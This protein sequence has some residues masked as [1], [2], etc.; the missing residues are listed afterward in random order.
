MRAKNDTQ[1]SPSRPAP[2]LRPALRAT[3]SVVTALLALGLA[4]L[5]LATTEVQ[6]A[7]PATLTVGVSPGNLPADGLSTA[8]VV[9]TATDA[10]G[11]PV[12]DGTTVVF[13]TTAGYLSNWATVYTGTTAGGVATATLT[14]APSNGDV[15]VTVHATSGGVS[16]SGAVTF[17]AAACQSDFT[18]WSEYAVNP[19]FDPAQKVYYPTVI[20]DANAFGH[21]QGDVISAS[22]P[23]TYV[24]TPYYKMW[25]ARS[26]A[27]QGLQFVYSDD[28]LNWHQFDGGAQLPGLAP[29][30]YHSRVLYDAGGF[31]GS[32]YYYKIWY[33][34]PS[35]SIYGITAVRTA[36]STDGLVWAN[37]QAL[38]QSL[39]MP[40]ITGASSG[41]NRGSYGPVDVLYD[42]SAI[43]SGTDPFDYSFV[44]YYDATTGG[45][46]QVGLG[47]S[48]DGVF[49][50][51]YGDGPVLS[52]GSD[53]WGDPTPWDSSYVGTGTVIK[54]AS[55]V[56]RFWYSGGTTALHHGIGYAV[57]ADGIHW[58]KSLDNP[59][60]HIN[61]GVSYR[62]AR[63]Y[64]PMVVRSTGGFD[65]HGPAAEYKMWFTADDGSNRAIGYAQLRPAAT[66][67]AA[68]GSSQSGVV[69]TPLS[70]P[71]VARAANTCDDPSPGVVVDFAVTGAPDGASGQNLSAQTAT[72]DAS[73]QASTTLTLGSH[74]GVY[75][76]TASSAGLS[77]S[78]VVFTATAVAPDLPPSGKWADKATAKAG[79]TLTYTIM[80]VNDQPVSTTRL[81]YDPIPAQTAYVSGSVSGGAFTGPAASQAQLAALQATVSASEA[82]AILW[83]DVLPPYSTH[84]IT[85]AVHINAGAQG[86]ITNT[87]AVYENSQLV[88]TLTATTELERYTLLLTSGNNQGGQVGD[89]LAPLV[90]TVQ[91]GDEQGVG[92]IP[93]EFAITGVPYGATGQRLSVETAT[94]DGSGQA[95]TVLTLGSHPGV[96]TVTASS[97]GLNGSPVVFVATAVAPDVA[98]FSKSV[99]KSL[100]EVGEVLTYTIVLANDSPVSTTLMLYDFIHP[101]TTCLTET[102][103]GGAFPASGA[104]A[105]QLAALDLP[106]PVA[107]GATE[108]VIWQGT[109]SPYST[110]AITFVVCINAGAQGIITNTASVYQNSQNIATLTAS[111]EVKWHTFY[112]P[113]VMKSAAAADR[114]PGEGQS[115]PD[116]TP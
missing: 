13:S 95:S 91:D 18:G 40:L 93:V 86:I 16:D 52:S 12:P 25:T 73:G 116:T 31:G 92:D 5:W 71:F 10:L 77:G 90:V 103:E 3:L 72:A 20:Y 68:S 78:P 45:F 37:D 115:E 64:T 102:I 94:T 98:G 110:H 70:A 4:L 84:L 11:G 39:T 69:N 58:S 59:I 76:V 41:W 87:A 106:A 54:D 74:P 75:T 6:A 112:L 65:G 66:L 8:T 85:F 108:A 80:L 2:V 79:Q 100:A 23:Y 34:D 99:D 43:N 35:V 82:G 113:I 33:W 63:T 38:T 50:T 42:P 15:A 14:S 56:Y 53:T 49:W 51:R 57:S 89:T 67:A 109:L 44:M 48:A 1:Q 88:A 22:L 36:D 24:V 32:G 7:G 55:G 111:T 96:Y 27:N 114:W 105:E 60:F 47:Y 30:G 101:D 19:V 9:V 62:T 104:S 17:Q 28:G 97:P 61:D 107:Q 21:S 29:Q 83:N 26:S 81:L 46:E